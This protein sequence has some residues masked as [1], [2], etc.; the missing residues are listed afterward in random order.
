MPGLDNVASI[1]SKYAPSSENNTGAYIQSVT[2]NMS[3]RLGS[4]VGALTRLDLSDPRV[5]K[6]LMQSITEHENFRGA[7]Q[8]FEGASFDKEVLAAA[9]SQWRSKVVNERDKIPSRGNVVVNQN[10]TINGADNPRAVGQAVA[11]ETLLAQNRYG[12]RNL[13]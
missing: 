10:I 12:Q 11:H 3:K 9:Q 2:A 8:Y 6:A 7:S 4:D 5:L 13:S 1:I